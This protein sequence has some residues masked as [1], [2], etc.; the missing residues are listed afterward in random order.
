LRNKTEIQK[1]L[2]VENLYDEAVKVSLRNCHSRWQQQCK[3][4]WR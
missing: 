2:T 3:W 1:H 4:K